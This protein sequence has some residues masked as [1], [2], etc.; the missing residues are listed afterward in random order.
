MP[1]HMRDFNEFDW[2]THYDNNFAGTGKGFAQMESAY[3]FGYDAAYDDRWAGRTW[4]DDF[5]NELRRE[6]ENTG[7]EE[8][9]D[10]VKDAVRHGWNEIR[11]EVDETF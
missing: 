4:D 6:W 8:A 10:D 7:V 11:E 1:D 3:R 9:W 5:D 2:R